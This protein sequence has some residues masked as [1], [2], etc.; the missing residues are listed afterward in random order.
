MLKDAKEHCDVLVVALQTDPTIDRD[1]KNK[2]IQTYE[3]RLI[4][5]QA[6]KYVDY[7]IQYA[8]EEDLLNILKCLS[9]NIRI[10][11][12]DWK[13][14]EYTGYYLDIPIYYHE[15]AHT[16]STSNLRKRIYKEEHKKNMTMDNVINFSSGFLN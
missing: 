12:S 14:K 6:V 11:G 7:I 2:P 16:Y 9:P 13:N 15:R 10:L 3:E 5:L 4:M 8:T 1:S